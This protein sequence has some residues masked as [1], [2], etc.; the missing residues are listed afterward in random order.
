MNI[1]SDQK[2]FFFNYIKT[3]NSQSEYKMSF[4]STLAVPSTP[5]RSQH[6]IF[7]P[8][9]LLLLDNFIMDC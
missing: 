6:N 1:I 2:A 9:M 3:K 7:F 8:R 4:N 5:T